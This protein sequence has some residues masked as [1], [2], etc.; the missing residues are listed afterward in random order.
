VPVAAAV[1][2]TLVCGVG[3]NLR[4]LSQEHGPRSVRS[5][6]RGRTLPPRAAHRRQAGVLWKNEEGN[7]VG[8]RQAY[9][10]DSGRRANNATTADRGHVLRSVQRPVHVNRH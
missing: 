3:G 7:D 2:G 5:N 6:V 4:G 10:L 1:E 8:V 9:A